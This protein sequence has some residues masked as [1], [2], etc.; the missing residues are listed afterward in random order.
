LRP[1]VEAGFYLISSQE[2]PIPMRKCMLLSIFLAVSAVSLRAADVL[3]LKNGDVLH[4]TW[5]RV[6]GNK[7]V[8]KSDTAGEMTVSAD[9]IKSLV[10]TVPASALLKDGSSVDGNLVLTES[11]K[12]QL[13]PTAQPS[14]TPIT[15]FIAIY[16]AKSFKALA[17][18]VHPK[19][20]QNWK[21]TANLGYSLITGDTQSRSLTSTVNAT[22][23][24]PDV[25]GLAVKWRT[26]FFLTALFSHATSTA[27]S[28]SSTSATVTSNTFSS[29]LRQD[30]LLT[31][32]DF[33]FAL[34]QYDYIQPQGIKL[35]QTYGGGFGRDLVHKP[36]FTF[37]AVGGL[38]YVRTGFENGTP[39]ENSAEIL[40]GEALTAKLGKY[41]ML[42][43]D[44][45][46]YP[47][48]S[49]TGE[50]RFDTSTAFAV[51]LSKRLSFSVSFVDF[52]LSN[53]APGSHQNNAT[54]STGIGVIF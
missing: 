43:H 46:F 30:R 41:V 15:S 19:L 14:A 39:I 32:D 38:T 31:A 1:G 40:V 36:K 11:G 28:T 16:P 21:G 49:Q 2:V 4:G 10:T 48:L 24:Q 54:L 26:T 29:G 53:P 44:I 18:G 6:Q 17:R 37:S 25:D 52:F 42:T 9:K 8:F 45:N 22:R 5:E 47:N 27:T 34:A 12:W 20:Y 7:L 50:Y 35:R 13:V 23:Q 3:T 33:V 51:P